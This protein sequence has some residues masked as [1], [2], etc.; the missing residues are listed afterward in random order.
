MG[1]DAG[2]AACHAVLTFQQVILGVLLPLCI[3]ARTWPPA[4]VPCPPPRTPAAAAVAGPRQ[5]RSRGVSWVRAAAA[6]A[7]RAWSSIDDALR[8]LLCGE[9]LDPLQLAL[10]AWLLAGNCWMLC[11]MRADAVVAAATVAPP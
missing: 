5:A 6:A 3:L 2:L 11:R 1:G 4:M 8:E 10:A 9:M 7:G